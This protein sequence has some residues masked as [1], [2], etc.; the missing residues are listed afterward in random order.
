[1][2]IAGGRPIGAETALRLKSEGWKAIKLKSRSFKR[3]LDT[4]KELERLDVFFLE[5]PLPR[6]DS[7]DWRSSTG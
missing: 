1:V 3:A 6:F 5:E 4:A 2:R 7:T